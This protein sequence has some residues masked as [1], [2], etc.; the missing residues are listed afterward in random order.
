MQGQQREGLWGLGHQLPSPREGVGREPPATHPSGTQLLAP[1]CHLYR[2]RHT[3]QQGG[4]CPCRSQELRAA[5]SVAGK[6]GRPRAKHLSHCWD[7]ARTCVMAW[8]CDSGA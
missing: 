4:V 7:T 2:V 5:F 1:R 6:K 8:A 3:R